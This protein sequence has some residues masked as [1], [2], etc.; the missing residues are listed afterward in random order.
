MVRKALYTWLDIYRISIFTLVSDVVVAAGI[1]EDSAVVTV[2]VALLDLSVVVVGS[3]DVD[4]MVEE[5]SLSCSDVVGSAE[6]VVGSAEVVRSVDV[7][8]SRDVV[9]GSSDVV[10][11]VEELLVC[12]SR[13]VDASVVEVGVSRVDVTSARLLD[14]LC[15]VVIVGSSDSVD[16]VVVDSGSEVVGRTCFVVLLGSI[17][18]VV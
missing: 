12:S 11:S 10:G 18:F 13:D 17:V 1:V 5:V 3:F 8:G 4:A 16:L 14:S 9:V 2:A 7:V 6:V 15:V